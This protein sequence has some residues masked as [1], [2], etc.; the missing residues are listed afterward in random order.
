M[1]IGFFHYI[2]VIADLALSGTENHITLSLCDVP[3]FLMIIF[4]FTT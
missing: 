4:Y 1:V 3:H 2:R